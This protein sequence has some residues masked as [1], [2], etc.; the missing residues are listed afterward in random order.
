MFS[1][2]AQCLIG[3]AVKAELQNAIETYGRNYNSQHEGY[4]VLK[5]EVE[6]AENEMNNILSDLNQLW[7][8]IKNNDKDIDS[9]LNIISGTA[10]F[11]ALEAVQVSAVAEK[12]RG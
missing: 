10:V 9:L 2:D 5:E 4:A 7:Q 3:K 1:V 8:K 6:E 11:L 12:M